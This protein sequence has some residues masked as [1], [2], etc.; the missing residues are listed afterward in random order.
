LKTRYLCRDSRIYSSPEEY[1][2]V[3]HLFSSFGYFSDEENEQVLRNIAG[4]L[5]PGGLFCFDILNRDT[6]L[7][8]VPQCGVR[9]NNGD[10]LIDRNRF[11]PLTGRLYNARIIIRNGKRRDLPFFLR[12]YNPTEIVALLERTGFVLEK[13]YGD[14]NGKPFEG[15]AKRMI[16]I[17]GKNV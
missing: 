17:A 12:L 5:K 4:S 16:L 1:D 13:I 15:G 7:K 3:I 14:W 11:D 8:D 2:R 6:F 9:E 10:L